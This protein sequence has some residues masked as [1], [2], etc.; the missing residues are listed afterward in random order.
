MIFIVFFGLIVAVVV[1]LNILDSSNVNQIKEYLKEQKCEPINYTNGKYQGACEDRIILIKNSFSVD[2]SKPEKL[3][4]YKDIKKL[5]KD[6]KKLV[7]Q[8]LNNE[9]I[10]NFKEKKDLDEFYNKVN[11]KK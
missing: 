1:G 3:V 2:V 6:E 9:I 8:V 10:L 11:S 7:I 4:L 5:K